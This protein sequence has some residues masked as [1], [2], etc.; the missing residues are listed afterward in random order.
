[1][2]FVEAILSFDG[3][4][5]S[6]LKAAMRDP[7]NHEAWAHLSPYISS[8]IQNYQ[9]AST[10]LVKAGLES[11]RDVDNAVLVIMIDAATK[12]DHWEPKL[13]A[14]Q[15]VQ[16]FGN[17]QL[18]H[19][20]LREFVA[21][22]QADKKLLVRVWALDAAVRIALFDGDEGAAREHIDAIDGRCPASMRARA[23]QLRDE[24]V[25]LR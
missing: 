22:Q 17:G 7:A 3:K 25:Q 6:E 20:G 15:C 18:Q 9:T 2:S 12:F 4:S 24:F 13:H 16:Y 8:D 11:G 1:M 19:A 23:R 10:W 5:I 21:V 14:L